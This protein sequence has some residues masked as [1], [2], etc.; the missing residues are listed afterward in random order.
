MKCVPQS[1]Q[2]CVAASYRNRR[3]L[4]PFTSCP[5]PLCTQTLVDCVCCW[6]EAVP[7]LFQA[8]TSPKHC[9]KPCYSK[10]SA[11]S[12]CLSCCGYHLPHPSHQDESGRR[13][14]HESVLL[15]H[16]YLNLTVCYRF[17]LI[18]SLNNKA[19]RYC[20]DSKDTPTLSFPSTPF[21]LQATPKQ[22]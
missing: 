4:G 18:L 20:L 10:P 5:V 12:P 15:A 16:P 11:H 13:G 9:L 8:L 3:H 7:L 14:Q 19:R 17:L 22:F 21:S 2:S 6:P 1:P